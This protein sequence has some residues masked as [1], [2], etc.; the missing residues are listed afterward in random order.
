MFG[1]G[2]WLYIILIYGIIC[3]ATIKFK[4]FGFFGI[5]FSI[6]SIFEIITYCNTN[7][8]TLDLTYRI[9]THGVG[10]VILL[11]MMTGILE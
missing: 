4:W 9:I 11:F 7:G 2:G 6:F 10:L 3:M 5:M 8:F 1:G